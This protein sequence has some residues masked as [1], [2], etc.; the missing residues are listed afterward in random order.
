MKNGPIAPSRR[1]QQAGQRLQRHAVAKS[2]WQFL[3]APWLSMTA[4][5]SR[6]RHELPF[7]RAT[8]YHGCVVS[9]CFATPYSLLFD[10]D[11]RLGRAHRTPTWLIQ[12][13]S[14][15]GGIRSFDFEDETGS[16]HFAPKGIRVPS[17]FPLTFIVLSRRCQVRRSGK[18]RQRLLF[19]APAGP[20]NRR[21]ISSRISDRLVNLKKKYDE[22]PRG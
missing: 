3:G 9:K 15:G 8:C 1:W 11:G 13:L 20:N 22:I 12:E 19:L 16:D 10:F 21:L 14:L 7:C 18:G 17:Y 2:S 4:T 6:D 5:Y